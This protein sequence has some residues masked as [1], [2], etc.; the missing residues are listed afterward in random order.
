VAISRLV[1]ARRVET[2]FTDTIITFSAGT[3]AVAATA[4]RNDNCFSAVN[5]T[6]VIGIVIVIST[7]AF[8]EGGGD[9]VDAGAGVC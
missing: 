6:F 1:A 5:D 9:S 8:R 3:I 7:I 2:S 4:D